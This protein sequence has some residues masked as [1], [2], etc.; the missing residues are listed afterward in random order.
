MCRVVNRVGV[1]AYCVLAW[2]SACCA[3]RSSAPVSAPA[4]T[5][6]VRFGATKYPPPWEWIH[7]P[8]RGVDFAVGEDGSVIAMAEGAVVLVGGVD[9]AEVGREVL[10][11][12]P[13]IGQWVAYGHLASIAVA[14]GDVVHRG[15]V[16]GTAVRPG[17]G[18]GASLSPEEWIPHRR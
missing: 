3:H 6:L 15:Q 18:V 2:L 8:H 4:P 7:R 12:H 16:I 11:D 5:I 10:I 1:F 17:H 14:T 13:S 9:A